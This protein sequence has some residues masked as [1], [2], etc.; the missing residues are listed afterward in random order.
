MNQHCNVK[1][2]GK[3]LF[4]CSSPGVAEIIFSNENNDFLLLTERKGTGS[5]RLLLDRCGELPLNKV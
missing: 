4:C 5:R 1:S 2:E 3:C